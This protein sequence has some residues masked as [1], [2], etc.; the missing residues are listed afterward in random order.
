MHLLLELAGR[1]RRPLF[2]PSLAMLTRAHACAVVILLSR[3]VVPF[4]PSLSNR[5]A[6]VAPAAPPNRRAAL[7]RAAAEDL[8]ELE[9]DPAAVARYRAMRD[10]AAR[11]ERVRRRRAR[12]QGK[13]RKEIVPVASVAELRAALG[14]GATT[15]RQLDVRGASPDWRARPPPRAHPVVRAL[16][17]RAAEGS[18]PGARREGD[19]KKIA[20][21]IEGGGMRGCIAG[22]MVTALHYLGLADAVDVVYGSSAGSLV[23]AYFIS[24]QMPHDGPEVY[25]D[26]LPTGGTDFIELR[27]AVRALGLGGLDVLRSRALLK[28]RFAEGSKALGPPVLKLDF[29]L[30]TLVQREKPLDWAAFWRAQPSQPLKVVASGLRTRRAR[31]LSA[32]GGHFASLPELA[33]C[34]RASMLLPGIAGPTI[35]DIEGLCDGTGGDE[36]LADALILEPIPYRSAIAEGATHTL[37]MRTRADG[38]KVTKDM[39]V[40]ERLLMRRFFKRK[41][42]LPEMYDHMR[43]GVNRRIYAEDILRLNRASARLDGDGDAAA[44]AA[45]AAASARGDG[46]VD[47]DAWL[48]AADAAVMCAIAPRADDARVGRLE[49]DRAAIFEGVRVGFAAAYDALVLGVDPSRAGEGAAVAREVFPDSILDRNPFA[50]AKLEAA[51]KSKTRRAQ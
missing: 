16:A 20:L 39:S 12:E 45:A 36:P 35:N 37:V 46:D 44:A 17:E 19:A 29:L 24:R 43:D 33:R 23:G 3:C 10:R 4:S 26:C 25:Y 32:E 48:A 7:A 13:K 22:G 27:N 31:V 6:P 21:A 47:D 41:N 1:A 30:E 15:L 18:R 38:D 49:T 28:D 40:I 9:L 34:M 5:R 42:D 11:I 2:L 51:L 8:D 50:E 14:D